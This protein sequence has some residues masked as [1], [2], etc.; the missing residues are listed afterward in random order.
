MRDSYS[1]NSKGF[2]F[3]AMSS[4][5]EADDAIDALH[6]RDWEV[7]VLCF[8]VFLSAWEGEGVRESV[9][10]GQN[11]LAVCFD[12]LVATARASAGLTTPPLFAAAA[13]T[14]LRNNRAAAWSSSARAR[15]ACEREK[16]GGL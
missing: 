11:F 9:V 1:G 5:A 8:D 12:V 4:A 7:S 3:V 2:A 13:N 16:K 14:T 15:C 6:G 10:G